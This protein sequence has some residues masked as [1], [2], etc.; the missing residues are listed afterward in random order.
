MKSRSSQIIQSPSFSELD[1]HYK[2][3]TCSNLGPDRC[4]LSN[5]N[6]DKKNVLK[7]FLAVL[8]HKSNTIPLPYFMM[9]HILLRKVDKANVMS[10]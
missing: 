4:N 1:H 2:N 10:L 8:F 5:F 6:E 3:L 9:V 7:Q